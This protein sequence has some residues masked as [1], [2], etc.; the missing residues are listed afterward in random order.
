[1]CFLRIKTCHSKYLFNF[2]VNRKSSHSKQNVNTFFQFYQYICLCKRRYLCCNFIKKIFVACVDQL[3]FLYGHFLYGTKFIWSL[4]IQSL[5]T[6][7]VQFLYS[8]KFIRFKIY[9]VQNLYGH[10]LYGSKFIQFKIYTVQNLYCRKRHK[11]MQP[12]CDT[13]VC[14]GRKGLKLGR[15]G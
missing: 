3:Y 15:L 7:Y 14:C 11:M 8:S 12:F 6:V 10:F 1:M 13:Y 2:V 4:F 5:F 9:T